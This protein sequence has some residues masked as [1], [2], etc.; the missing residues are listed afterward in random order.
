MIYR[1]AIP[2]PATRPNAASRPNL[3][4]PRSLWRSNEFVKYFTRYD[5][6]LSAYCARLKRSNN[7]EPEPQWEEKCG[8]PV[9][10]D[11]SGQTAAL[12]FLRVALVP[13]FFG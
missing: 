11:V 8:K 6:V 12:Q 13:I 9:M 2:E 1:F 5:N 10:A 3:R 7:R 4:S